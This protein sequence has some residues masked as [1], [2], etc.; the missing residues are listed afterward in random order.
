MHSTCKLRTSRPVAWRVP[1]AAAVAVAAAA[2]RCAACDTCS[3]QPVTSASAARAPPR[4]SLPRVRS[5]ARIAYCRRGVRSA[6][7]ARCWRAPP[8]AAATP[9][10]VAPAA[11]AAPPPAPPAVEMTHGRCGGG[12]GHPH[13]SGGQ[14]APLGQA[15]GGGAVSGR[16]A[17]AR[18]GV[19]DERQ[20]AAEHAAP[21]RVRTTPSRAHVAREDRATS[22]REGWYDHSG[23]LHKTSDL[24]SDTFLGQS[25]RA[26][27][28]PVPP[29]EE[30]EVR[31][32][33]PSPRRSRPDSQQRHHRGPEDQQRPHLIF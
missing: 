1:P 3:L 22:R 5:W 8:A 7:A 28:W 23:L 19:I 15:A 32:H 11:P 21:T 12:R 17:S 14:A 6:C 4:A 27:S 26:A 24:Q 20:N 2:V 13:V 10:A 18:G 30:E 16:G 9:L 29:L 25:L 31:P 33:Q